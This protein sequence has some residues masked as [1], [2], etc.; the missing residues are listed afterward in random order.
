MITPT[1]IMMTIIMMIIMMTIIIM[2]S[3]GQ[4]WQ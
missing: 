4:N 3:P 1:E 2:I